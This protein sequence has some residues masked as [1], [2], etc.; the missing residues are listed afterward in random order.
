MAIV[1]EVV[2]WRCFVMLIDRAFGGKEEGGALQ[3]TKS[4]PCSLVTAGRD[5]KHLSAHRLPCSFNLYL[6]SLSPPQLPKQRPGFT[7]TIFQW[8]N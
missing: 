8:S 4:C 5:G 3:G 7:E 2:V 1:D 6:E